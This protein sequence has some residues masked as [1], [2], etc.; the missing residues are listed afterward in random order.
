MRGVRFSGEGVFWLLVVLAIGAG[1]YLF[2][3]RHPPKPPARFYDKGHV[4]KHA[5]SGPDILRG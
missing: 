5:S 1:L 4:E 3:V 2:T